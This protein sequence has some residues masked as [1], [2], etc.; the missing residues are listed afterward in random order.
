MS[1]D[2]PKGAMLEVWYDHN[3][4][5]PGSKQRWYQRDDE[6]RVYRGREFKYC[7]QAIMMTRDMYRNVAGKK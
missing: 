4:L 5:G 7:Q 2:S 1:F 6:V 3:V